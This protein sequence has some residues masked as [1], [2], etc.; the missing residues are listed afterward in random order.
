M[1]I[2]LHELKLPVLRGV[3]GRVLDQEG[4]DA[5]DR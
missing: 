2:K 3:G 5:E 4:K 1:L